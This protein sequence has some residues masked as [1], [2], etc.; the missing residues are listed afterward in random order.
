ML[1]PHLHLYKHIHLQYGVLLLIVFVLELSAA[2]FATVLQGRVG[3]MLERTMFETLRAYP[4]YPYAAQAVD[5]M[6]Y[7][8]DC[9][10]VQ[11]LEDW[12]G[13]LPIPADAANTTIMVPPSC[14][15]SAVLDTCSEYIMEGCFRRLEF[16]VSQSTIIIAMGSIS[17]AFVQIL[18]VVSAFMLAKTIRRTKSLREAR[19]WQLHQSLGIVIG[20]RSGSENDKA[21]YEDYSQLKTGQI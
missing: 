17:V 19:R 10:G 6:Q 9:C 4:N 8:L 13:I 21:S 11:N 1:P 2:V 14:C 20:G 7:K 18:G 16:V 15:R 3:D 5:L 12:T